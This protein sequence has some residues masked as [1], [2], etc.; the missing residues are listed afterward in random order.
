MAR[1]KKL[2]ARLMCSTVLNITHIFEYK[3][4]DYIQ[5]ELTSFIEQYGKDAHISFDSF[6]DSYTVINLILL[7][8]EPDKRAGLALKA[9]GARKSLGSMSSVFRHIGVLE[10]KAT[11]RLSL[12]AKQKDP[13][14][15][16]LRLRVSSKEA[17]DRMMKVR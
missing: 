12:F 8:D 3:T 13:R 1:S 10:R 11:G 2:P 6:D 15:L 7:E 16:G 9:M 5:T 4:L 17:L 14:R